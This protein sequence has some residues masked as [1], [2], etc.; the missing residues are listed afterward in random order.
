MFKQ[1]FFLL[2]EFFR[3]NIL[4]A[5]GDGRDFILSG[6]WPRRGTRL[7]LTL[8]HRSLYLQIIKIP[9]SVPEEK[10][11]SALKL[12][13]QRLLQL[14]EEKEDVSLAFFSLDFSENSR[15]KAPSQRRYLVAFQRQEFL[16]SLRRKFPSHMVICGVFPAWAAFWAWLQNRGLLKDGFFLA[17]TPYGLEG[18]EW[19]GGR[20]LKIL[21]STKEAAQK[22]LQGEVFQLEGE[23]AARAL[24]EG[25]TLIPEIF[26]KQA[27]SF[28]LYPLRTRLRVPLK[29]LFLWLLPFLIWTTGWGL[30]SWENHLLLQETALKK[31]L[32]QWQQKEAQ[33]SQQLQEREALKELAA[34][35]KD[36]ETRPPLLE[37][38]NELARLL[39]DDTWIRKLDFR[40]PDILQLWGESGNALEVIKKLEESPYFLEVKILSSITKNP[41][42]GKERFALR[43]KIRLTSSDSFEEGSVKGK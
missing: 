22:V 40:T 31:Q 29:A 39:P 16:A 6:A 9:A 38:L 11:L 20:L 3:P 33:L 12:E 36:F 27:P 2:E 24:A 30:K 41:R 37:V 28:D 26:G 8:S 7:Y 23:K 14:L 4:G 42:T 21:P 18:F 19:R 10:V 1:Y 13:A 15:E 5:Y 32:Q 25:A 34:H 35:V 17:E 43:T